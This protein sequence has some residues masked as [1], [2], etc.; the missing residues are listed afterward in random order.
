MG[1]TKYSFCV[2]LYV[3]TSA[4]ILWGWDSKLNSHPNRMSTVP[5]PTKLRPTESEAPIVEME[6]NVEA[7]SAR[8]AVP[9]ASSV[10]DRPTSQGLLRR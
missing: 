5:R 4:A 2:I 3:Y 7:A 10:Q 9:N 6:E 8:P 1:L